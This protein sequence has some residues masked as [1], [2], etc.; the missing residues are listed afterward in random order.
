MAYREQ[1]LG[2]LVRRDPK[3]ATVQILAAYRRAAGHT[4]T[5]ATAL[6]VSPRSLER[7]TSKLG[8]GPKVEALRDRLGTKRGGRSFKRA[9]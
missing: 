2:Y 8:L 9:S 5:A 1:D 6:D 7:W 3:R 4:L